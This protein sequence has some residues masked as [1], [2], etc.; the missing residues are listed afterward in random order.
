VEKKD[1][2]AEADK[3]KAAAAEKKAYVAPAAEA[4]TGDSVEVQAFFK[5]LE[6]LLKKNQFLGG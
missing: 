6:E 1:K 2:K 4:K 5:S 3:K